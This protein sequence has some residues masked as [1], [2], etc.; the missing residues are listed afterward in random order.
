MFKTIPFT[1]ISQDSLSGLCEVKFSAPVSL[2][3]HF[4]IK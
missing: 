3:T 4:L 2:R 1:P